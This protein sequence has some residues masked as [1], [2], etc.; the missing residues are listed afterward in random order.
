MK[1]ILLRVGGK[2]VCAS[3]NDASRTYYS[4]VYLSLDALCDMTKCHRD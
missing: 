4:E 2:L 3:R 1:G